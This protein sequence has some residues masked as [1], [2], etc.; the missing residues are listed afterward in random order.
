M[1][2]ITKNGRFPSSALIRQGRTPITKNVRVVDGA[3]NPLQSTYRKRALGLVKHGRAR[4][5]DPDT[6]ELTRPPDPQGEETIMQTQS[7]DQDTTTTAPFGVNS[8]SPASQ[9]PSSRPV[10]ASD[11]LERIDML[12]A[13]TAYLRESVH[14]LKQ[15]ESAGVGDAGSR[16]DIGTQAKATAIASVVEQ[17]EQTNQKMI[18]LLDRMYDDLSPSTA[19]RKQ[20]RSPEETK[21][22]ERLIDQSSEMS[23]DTL[24]AFLDALA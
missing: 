8:G 17:R 13:E 6:I 22:I 1:T 2:P 14:A 23:D 24:R 5:I 12:I 9:T 7:Q 15:I 16:G 19:M 10:A 11:I 3:G 18:A 21:L 4:F 20:P